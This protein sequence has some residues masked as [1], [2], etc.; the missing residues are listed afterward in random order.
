MHCPSTG[1]ESSLLVRPSQ[2]H[3]PPRTSYQVAAAT[4]TQENRGERE[5][6]EKERRQGKNGCT[7]IANTWQNG[8]N[9]NK[10]T[11]K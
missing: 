2:N 10:S 6:T 4:N 7:D 3:P 8:L 11:H 5:E 1:P 9:K